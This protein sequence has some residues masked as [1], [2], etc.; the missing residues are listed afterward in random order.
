MRKPEQDYTKFNAAC[1]GRGHEIAERL[2]VRRGKSR[3]MYYCP[4]GKG[5]SRGYDRTPSLSINNETGQFHCFGC[6][7]SGNL[8]TLA[9]LTGHANGYETVADM[10]GLSNTSTQLPRR[11]YGKR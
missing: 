3:G 4:N 1:A 6:Q 2:G 8:I 10:V 5:H 7:L 9:E 11:K